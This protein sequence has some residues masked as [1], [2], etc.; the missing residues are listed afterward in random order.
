[1]REG[2]GRNRNLSSEEHH[3]GDFL[4]EL[5]RLPCAAVL[6]RCWRRLALGGAAASAEP[7]CVDA[8]LVYV[9][10]VEHFSLAPGQLREVCQQDVIADR[11]LSAAGRNYSPSVILVSVTF[12]VE[13]SSVVFLLV[14]AFASPVVPSTSDFVTT[15]VEQLLWACRFATFPLGYS[16]DSSSGPKAWSLVW[17]SMWAHCPLTRG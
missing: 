17:H 14:A 2:Q 1:M 11:Q 3:Q 5:Q 12:V 15:V 16:V 6:E 10:P 4:N 7:A 8:A 9:Q 13:A